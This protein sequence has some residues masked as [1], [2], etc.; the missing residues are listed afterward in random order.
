MQYQLKSL[1]ESS[2]LAVLMVILAL[3]AV[4]VPILGMV[5]VLLFPLPLIVIVVRHGLKIGIMAT[6]VATFLLGVLLSPLVSLKLICVFAPCGLALGFGY[7]KGYGAVKIFLIALFVSLC[8]KILGLSLAFFL[9]GIEP[10]SLQF[11][12]LEESFE[13]SLAIYKSLHMSPEQIATAKETFA[14]NLKMMRL[15]LPFMV[16]LMALMDTAINFIFGAKVLARLGHSIPSFP[17]FHQWRLSIGFL[18]LFGFSLVGLYWGTSREITLLHQISFNGN[19]IAIFAGLIEGLALFQ[20]ICRH[21]KVSK[22][23]RALLLIFI[24]LSGFLLELLIFTGLFDMV[25]DYRRRFG[26]R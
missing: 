15:L 21:Y 8:S 10:F 18:Y 4:Y 26:R 20:Y 12:M 17:P 7:K 23:L 13:E 24:V 5:A 3:L 19:M 2:V 22:W 16:V 11:S 6:L 9:T 1:T 25:F 14:E